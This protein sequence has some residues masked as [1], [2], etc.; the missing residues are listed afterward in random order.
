M[1]KFKKQLFLLLLLVGFSTQ[2]FAQVPIEVTGFGGYT[3]KNSFPISG[4]KAVLGEGGV[5]GASLAFGI[6]DDLDIELSYS[7][8]ESL[9]Q[10]SAP[11]F[12]ISFR[13][14]G[15]VDYWMIGGVKNFQANNPNLYFFTH[16]RLGGVTFST[17]D[18]TP[19]SVTHF[20][21]AFGGGLKFFLSDQMGIKLTGNMQF[22][23]TNVGAGLY[24]GTGGA[25]AGI[26]TWSPILQFNF[27]GGIFFRLNR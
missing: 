15:N 22:P 11:V 18:K 20:A 21:A 27:D 12:D 6:Q 13:E 19:D 2:V 26:S 23:I 10:A 1:G 9:F 8:Q 3:F 25:G 17:K 24:F 14:S 7:R 5:F 4:G 16:L